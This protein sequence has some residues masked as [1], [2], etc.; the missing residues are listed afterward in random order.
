LSYPEDSENGLGL[1]DSLS[2][3]FTIDYYF[4]IFFQAL[5]SEIVEAVMGLN[6]RWWITL[7]F[8]NNNKT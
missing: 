4:V 6:E 7:F 2:L 3:N 5:F 1:L 8:P